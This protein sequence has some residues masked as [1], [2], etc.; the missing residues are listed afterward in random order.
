MV[1]GQSSTLRLQ[2]KFN[3]HL[4]GQIATFDGFRNGWYYCVAY[5]RQRC[6]IYHSAATALYHPEVADK[7]VAELEFQPGTPGKSHGPS[8]GR[9]DH[10]RLDR[11]L[12]P[13]GKLGF[14][15]SIIARGRVRCFPN[16]R[17]SDQ[18]RCCRRGRKERL[19][20]Q[21]VNRRLWDRCRFWLCLPDDLPNRLWPWRFF[22]RRFQ[23]IDCN[24]DLWL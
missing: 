15:V 22:G 21:L 4:V 12:Q 11:R 2:L 5:R 20:R 17:F 6:L 3:R 24:H 10:R 1:L 19:R 16:R 18:R 23:I 8:S 14:P 7:A 13:H 9:I